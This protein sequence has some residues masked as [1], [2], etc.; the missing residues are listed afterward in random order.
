MSKLPDRWECDRCRRPM[1]TRYR[2]Q[3]G[4]LHSLSFGPHIRHLEMLRDTEMPDEQK[5]QM[6]YSLYG[7]E[8]S[9]VARE[10]LEILEDGQFVVKLPR[11]DRRVYMGEELALDLCPSCYKLLMRFLL[12][13]IAYVQGGSAPCGMFIVPDDRKGVDSLWRRLFGRISKTAA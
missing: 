5:Q 10:A 7:Q 11:S 3:M 9:R 1:E 4:L 13:D 8:A 2:G 12:G 6:M